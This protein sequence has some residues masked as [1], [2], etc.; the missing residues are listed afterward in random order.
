MKI[1]DIF[2]LEKT[3]YELDF[4][5]I[6]TEVDTPLF[7]DPYFISKQQFP[8][9]QRSYTT[10]KS[11]FNYLLSLLRK[12][13]IKE[14][15]ELFSHL[16][17]S[18]EIC[19]G[20]SKGKPSGKGMG[21]TDGERIF[22]N[23]IK[24]KAYETGLMEDIEDFRIFVPNVDKDKVSDMTT[25]IIKKH[26]I[27]YTQEQCK[28]WDIKLT[29]G[30][31]SGHFW[32]EK[33]KVWEDEYT[34]MLVIDGRKILLV[35]KRIVSYS[36]EYTHEKYKQHFVLNFLQN[37]HLRLQT[38]LVKERK[39]KFKTKYVTKKSVEEYE[40]KFNLLDKKW[41]ADFT[42]EHPEVFAEFKYK[43]INKIQSFEN[44]ELCKEELGNITN[45][46][47]SRLKSIPPG[48]ENA[49]IYHKTVLGIMELLF[50]PYLAN[51]K[52]EQEIHDGR[53]RIDITFD[54][55]AESG[56]F[57]RL[58]T[59]YDIPSNFIIIECKNYSKD[60]KNPELDQLSGRFSANRGKFGISVCRTIENM[61]LFI[62]RCIDT[63]KDGR[64]LIIPIIDSDL[65]EM[66]E[67]YSSSGKHS[68]EKF[69][70]DK[71]H[72]IGIR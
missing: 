15:K 32:E 67:N 63:Y 11:Y 41:L 50:Y 14:A 43:A 64:G 54:N 23:L 30:V 16:G 69:F 31:P 49:N 24:S 7:L 71:F 29:C 36:K 52:I 51:P 39:D 65:I 34:D 6:N 40:G 59:T 3:Q 25:N 19:L 72:E 33:Q 70:Q 46:L 27:E 18:N 47:I 45:Y 21:E 48:A 53:K 58:S 35:P 38:G 37:E 55:C 8:F 10:L 62:N 61:D 57:F 26:L 42:L 17:E 28:I 20:M 60:L 9:A 1:S 13:R 66:L 5:D 68:W 56:F 2:K 22:S 44:E 12:Q 4:V